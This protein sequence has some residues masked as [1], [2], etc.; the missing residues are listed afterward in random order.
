MS[1]VPIRDD[2]REPESEVRLCRNG[3]GRPVCGDEK[4]P[5][6][7]LCAEC[8]KK[9]VESRSATHRARSDTRRDIDDATFEGKA[10]ALVSAGR[11]LDKRIAGVK[12]RRNQLRDE[13]TLLREAADLWRDTCRRLADAPDGRS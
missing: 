9:A 5:F 4:G 8:K 7:N 1:V 12:E 3:D 13:M 11:V 2:M 10:R 6:K